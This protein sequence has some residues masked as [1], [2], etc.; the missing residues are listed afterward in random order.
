MDLAKLSRRPA[1]DEVYESLRQA[2]VAHGFQPGERLHIPEI[3]AKLGV[4]ATPVRQA[5]Q[6]LAGEG[7]IEIH[8][9]S[10]TYVASLTIQDIED[11]FDIRCALECL[12]AEKAVQRISV[13]EME[14]MRELRDAL[15]REVLDDESRQRHERDNSE[16]HAIIVRASG[17]RRLQEI[18]D[19]LKANIQIARVHVAEGYRDVPWDQERAEH[20]DIFAAL[21]GRDG[22]RLEAALRAHIQR[23]KRSLIGGL[24]N[25]SSSA[26]GAA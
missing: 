19:S 18:H 9:R 15:R 10:G 5:I 4:S 21:E 17:N 7:L 13:E 22:K 8:P 6:K 14:R 1:T 12:A 25:V 3:S 20:E 2:I 16:F 24:M 11:T 26:H 23:A